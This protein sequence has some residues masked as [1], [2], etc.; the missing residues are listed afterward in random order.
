[1]NTE[2][3]NVNRT[4]IFLTIVNSRTRAKFAEAVC[5]LGANGGEASPK[6]IPGGFLVFLTPPTLSLLATEAYL[7]TLFLVNYRTSIICWLADVN[8]LCLNNVNNTNGC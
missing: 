7:C 3:Q 5:A 6:Q 8:N 2:Q 4:K 1:M